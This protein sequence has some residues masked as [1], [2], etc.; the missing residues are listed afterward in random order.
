MLLRQRQLGRARCAGDAPPVA[1]Q[2]RDPPPSCT[3]MAERPLRLPLPASLA[4]QPPFPGRGGAACAL[5]LG[6]VGMDEAVGQSPPS[7]G[8]PPY[9]GCPMRGGGGGAAGAVAAAAGGRASRAPWRPLP[10]T[11][12]PPPASTRRTRRCGARVRT[13]PSANG[14]GA[15]LGGERRGGP[16]PSDVPLHRAAALVGVRASGEAAKHGPAPGKPGW[17]R[18]LRAAFFPGCCRARRGRCPLSAPGP[19]RLEGPAGPG[20]AHSAVQCVAR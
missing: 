11:P 13:R 2:P 7:S 15:W 5:S 14:T 1:G 9:G 17:R 6:A 3:V 4:A 8:G 12:S 19:E 20:N 18:E 16:G 10:A